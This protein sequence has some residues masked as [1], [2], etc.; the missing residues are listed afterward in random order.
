MVFGRSDYLT[1]SWATYGATARLSIA[2]RRA[3]W[4]VELSVDAGRTWSYRATERLK[5]DLL[6][7]RVAIGRTW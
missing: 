4:P 5:R 6:G 3:R 7:A 1:C 2:R